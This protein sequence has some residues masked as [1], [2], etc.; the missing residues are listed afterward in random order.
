MTRIH[1]TPTP[2]LNTSVLP[3]LGVRGLRIAIYVR[4][5]K[6][7][8]QSMAGVNRQEALCREMIAQRYPGDHT[9]TVYSDNNI[10]AWSGARRPDYERLMADV[11]AGNLDL[12]VCYA[13]DRLYRRVRLLEDII[14]MTEVNGSFVP[15]VGVRSGD[16]DLATADGRM[17]ARM[18]AAVAQHSSDKTSERLKDRNAEEAAKG[19][20]PPGPAPYGYTRMPNPGGAK[21]G[22]TYVINEPEARIVREVVTSIE[23]GDSMVSIA[24]ALNY[25]G[26]PKRSGTEWKPDDIRRM[27]MSP[28]IAGLRG[29]TPR[30]KKGKVWRQS[31]TGKG[32]WKAI[33]PAHRWEA[34]EETLSDDSRRQRSPGTNYWL[35][36]VLVTE[37]GRPLVGSVTRGSNGIDRRIYRPTSKPFVS[38]DADQVEDAVGRVLRLA[39]SEVVGVET[40]DVTDDEIALAD[41]LEAIDAELGDLSRRVK[42][43]TDH[44]DYLLPVERNG[45]RAGLLEHRAKVIADMPAAQQRSILA[46]GKTLADEWDDLDAGD[47][48]FMALDLLGHVTVTA[49]GRA[50]VPVPERLSFE[51]GFPVP[52][53]AA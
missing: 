17:H 15:I 47:R 12:V 22:H 41:Q 38:I 50:K 44:P 53:A 28:A 24:R 1:L 45:A 43:P 13:T 18:L 52:G 11:Q 20:A 23:A 7:D 33:V 35:S 4:I 34:I 6:D 49:V 8:T 37:D 5:S 14:T 19:F 48:R 36:T 3:H 40:P 10:S 9:I 46:P 25:R 30:A 29:H 2:D 31:V 21:C 42:L 27:V 51:K 32:N 39:G 16:L 26:I